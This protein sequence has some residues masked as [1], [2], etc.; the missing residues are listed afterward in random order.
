MF[1]ITENITKRPVFSCI[2]RNISE[3]YNN[4][5][6]VGPG[7]ICEV[8]PSY[9]HIPPLDERLVRRRDLYRTKRSDNKKQTSMLPVG[10]ELINPARKLAQT[11]AL[12]LAGK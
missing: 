11:H 1:V 6:P 5:F 7:L 12:D 4:F 10:F 8:P 3:V 9:S 2:A